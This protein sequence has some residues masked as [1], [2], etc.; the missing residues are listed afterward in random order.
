MGVLFTYIILFSLK[1]P[2]NFFGFPYLIKKSSIYLIGFF[3]FIFVFCFNFVSN[4]S[5]KL[6]VVW[7]RTFDL[8]PILL[9]TDPSRGNQFEKIY[10]GLSNSFNN[11]IPKPS[12]FIVGGF[13]YRNTDVGISYFIYNQG[14]ILLLVFL[15]IYFYI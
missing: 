3:S 4:T 11:L 1:I 15:C 2:S 14:F 13:M 6:G 9:G 5:E 8:L 12:F 10:E 7:R